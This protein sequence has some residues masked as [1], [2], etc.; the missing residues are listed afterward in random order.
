M[1]NDY[2][3]LSIKTNKHQDCDSAIPNLHTYSSNEETQSLL[4]P[5]D[6][7]LPRNGTSGDILKNH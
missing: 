1:T 6:Q 5:M 7:K 3:N 4:P 2:K